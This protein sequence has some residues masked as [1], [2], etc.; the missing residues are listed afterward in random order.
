MDMDTWG[1]WMPC[2]ISIAGK[3]LAFLCVFCLVV[4]FGLIFASRDGILPFG[5]WLRLA[6]SAETQNP[7]PEANVQR[8]SLQTTSPKVWGGGQG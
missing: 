3:K 1:R 6:E 5:A 8:L 2:L 4:F 7:N